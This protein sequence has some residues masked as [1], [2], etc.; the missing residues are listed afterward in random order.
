MLSERDTRFAQAIWRV[1]R[2]TFTK[3]GLVMVGQQTDGSHWLKYVRWDVISRWR[4]RAKAAEGSLRYPYAFAS[5]ERAFPNISGGILWLMSS[6]HY[7]S[8]RQ[9]PSI[10]A[11]LEISDVV[12]SDHPKADHV[13]SE[14][15]S[16]GPWVAIAAEVPDAYLPL[17]NVSQTLEKLRFQGKVKRLPETPR[18]PGTSLAERPYSHIPQHFRSH[19][20]IA[21]ESIHYLETFAE[22]VRLGRRVFVSYRWSDFRDDIW[23]DELATVL[24]DHTVSCWLDKRNVPQANSAHYKNRLLRNI[25][26]DAI[27]QSAWLVALMRPGY[28]KDAETGIPT[29]VRYEWNEAGR[30]DRMNRV[31]VL[32]GEQ[33]AAHDWIDP[34]R[35]KVITVRPE[36]SPS[37]IAQHLLALLASSAVT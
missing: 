34:D 15:K 37:T 8:Y 16:F 29:W 23:V 31:A 1:A 18:L 7:G 30:H 32:F 10:I 26:D 33:S 17:N 14:V 25:L 19:R 20:V 22:A 24:S 2:G 28:V 36:A 9:P 4:S 13:D 11:R 12:A 3:L 27:R 5:R 6:P 35:D 21:Q